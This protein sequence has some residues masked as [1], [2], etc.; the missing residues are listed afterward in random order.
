MFD[1]T[2]H[3]GASPGA[4]AFTWSGVSRLAL[5]HDGDLVAEAG[6]RAFRLHRPNWAFSVFVSGEA[7]RRITATILVDVV[8]G[9]PLDVVPASITAQYTRGGAYLGPVRQVSF[10]SPSPVAASWTADASVIPSSG[11]VKT[12][13]AINFAFDST[14]S[15][16]VYHGRITAVTG[17]TVAI[18]VTWT[19]AAHPTGLAAGTYKTN[20][21]IRGS[22]PDSTI[23][24]G[25]P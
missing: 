14:L 1:V 12:P 23:T 10:V 16:G 13:G 22:Y 2:L 19:L 8:S 20:L 17:S 24:R 11:F 9:A 5:E 7:G 6:T 4:L 18:P 15:E 3:P 21:S 25:S